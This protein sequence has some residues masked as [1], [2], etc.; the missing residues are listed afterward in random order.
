M[1]R[2][3]TLFGPVERVDSE[4][5]DLGVAHPKADK[6]VL[7]STSISSHRPSPLKP[8]GGLQEVR[9]GS[10]SALSSEDPIY[11]PRGNHV[12]FYRSDA[13]SPQSERA[14]LQRRRHCQRPVPIQEHTIHERLSR[15][16]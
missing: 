12:R 14:E 11:R 2:G 8:I 10:R 4:G 5:I 15:A 1:G 9:C 7:G 16:D 3:G 6:S 13:E